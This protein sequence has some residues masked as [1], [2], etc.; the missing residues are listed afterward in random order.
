MHVASSEEAGVVGRIA[1]LL[2]ELDEIFMRFQAL[3]DDRLL[4]HRDLRF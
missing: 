1:E 2:L 3:F 4:R